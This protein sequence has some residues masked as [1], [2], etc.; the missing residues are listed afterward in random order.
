MDHLRRPVI[1]P[2]HVL[3][4]PRLIFGVIPVPIVVLAT[5]SEAERRAYV[6]A[7]NK[8]AENAGAARSSQPRLG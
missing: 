2:I 8:L 3:R 5:M 6:L 7:D 1:G 4:P